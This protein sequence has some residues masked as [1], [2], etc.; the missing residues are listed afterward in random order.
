METDALSLQYCLRYLILAIH[1]IY[2]GM[3]SAQTEHYVKQ[4]PWA[5]DGDAAWGTD[6]DE[7]H[8]YFCTGTYC[9]EEDVECTKVAKT[10]L[11]GKLIWY[12]RF[13][14][15]P[16]FGSSKLCHSESSI[17]VCID[18][19]YNSPRGDPYV[20]LAPAV[21]KLNKEGDS[22]W[23]KIYYPPQ[24]SLWSITEDAVDIKY[25]NNS[26]FLLSYRIQWNLPS[27]RA[28]YHLTKLDTN[29]EIIWKRD[30]NTHHYPVTYAPWLFWFKVNERGESQICG[31][32]DSLSIYKIPVQIIYD[33]D[34]NEIMNKK[35]LSSELGRIGTKTY[36]HVY[37]TFT[38]NKKSMWVA[39]IEHPA[40]EDKFLVYSFDSS[41]LLRWKIIV[42][43]HAEIIDYPYAFGWKNGDM[44]CLYISYEK[45]YIKEDRVDG[46]GL[47]RVDDQGNIKWKRRYYSYPYDRLRRTQFIMDHISE[48]RDNGI[49][50]GGSYYFINAWREKE[51]DAVLIKLDSIGCP[52]PDCTE[53]DTVNILTPIITSLENHEIIE[54]PFKWNYS[55]NDDELVIKFDQDVVKPNLMLSLMDLRGE[56]IYQWKVQSWESE[57]FIKLFN[58]PAGLYYIRLASTKCVKSFGFVKSR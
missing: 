10:D 31:T 40:G 24:D 49:L 48:T 3:V 41:L 11:E 51:D 25:Y 15:K 9:Y 21:C 46:F 17:F 23:V 53:A 58:F 18:Y 8:Y 20:I 2:C 56:V 36:F 12:K 57:T 22:N 50:V 4:Y 37:G 32:V 27:N 55:L 19:F 38:I 16:Q 34:G 44:V 26:L 30:L 52:F 54:N 29:G 33:D 5:R 47:F 28:S 6:V 1:L 35:L 39:D 14:R 45:E 7:E 13:V 43:A 42:P